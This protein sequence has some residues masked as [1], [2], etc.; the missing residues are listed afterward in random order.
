MKQG[1][2]Q[3]HASIISFFS[4]LIDLVII[5]L[6]LWGGL[7]LMG[8]D[9]SALSLVSGGLIASVFFQ[10]M[11]NVRG[12]YLSMRG[13]SIRS[14]INKSLK[15]WFVS[16][17]LAAVIIYVFTPEGHDI[18]GLLALWFIVVSI[19]FIFSRLL[20]RSF[21]R[22][23]RSRGFNQR[24]VIIVGAGEVGTLL[25][26]N[27]CECT[28]FGLTIKGFYDND[29]EKKYVNAKEQSLD[30][31]GD[32]N[33]LINPEAIQGV[34]RVYITLSM[35]QMPYIQ[36]LVSF[37]ANSTCSVIYV[38]D[39]FSFDLLNSR[40]GHLNGIPTISIYDTP[41]EGANLMVKRIEDIVLATLILVLISPLMILIAIAIKLTTPGPIFFKQNRYGVDGKLIEVW[42]FRSMTVMD[43]GDNIVQATKGDSR[44]TKLGAF[45]R[46]TSLDEFPQF[47][48]VLQGDMSIVGPRPHA[49]AHNE[50][51]RTLIG[52]YMLRHKVKPG[53][54]GWAQING[55]RGETDT[56]DKMQKRIEFDLHYISHWSLYWDIKII[57]KTI[58]KGFVDK[59]AY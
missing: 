52:G 51:Y 56:L 50:E 8:D 17:L 35:E 19:Y 31:L 44:I 23:I 30:I 41:M 21:L 9:F 58:F 49:I 40:M 32:L 45:L 3:A 11:A 39:V 18:K 42:K 55:W 47:F 10:F 4:Q 7:I 37:L 26:N 1:I 54:T 2:L 48:N 6:F 24:K 59:N 53:I 15:Y 13:E 29:C 16:F 27:I 25:A 28:E 22:F 33:D 36:K 14:E 57:I 12:L 20:L 5:P 38:P 43:N 34:D 46:Q